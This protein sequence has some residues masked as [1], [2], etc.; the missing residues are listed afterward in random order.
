[1]TD[2]KHISEILAELMEKLAES[3]TTEK[4]SV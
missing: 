2:F 3:E 4:E 1:M